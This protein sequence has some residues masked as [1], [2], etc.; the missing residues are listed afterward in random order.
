MEAVNELAADYIPML[1]GQ[2]EEL[3]NAKDKPEEASDYQNCE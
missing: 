3:K 1:S 2:E